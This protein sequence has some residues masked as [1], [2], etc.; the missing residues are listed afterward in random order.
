MLKNTSGTKET[1]ADGV[2][3]GKPAR[4]EG[5]IQVIDVR[6]KKATI[7]W[8]KPADDGGSPISH[9]VLEKMDMV[10]RQ[11]FSLGS[12]TVYKRPYLQF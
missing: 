3:L 8:K 9:Y 7:K 2:V 10:N 1:S 12:N 11:N 4:P 6:A 5:P